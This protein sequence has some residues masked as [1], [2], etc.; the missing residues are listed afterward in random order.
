MKK[1]YTLFLIIFIL[2]FIAAP[3]AEA[4]NPDR[5]GEAGAPELLMNPWARSAGLHTM[6]TS[7]VTGVDAMRLNVAGLSRINRTEVALS[8]ARYLDG[9]GIFMNAFGLA[10]RIGQKNSAFGVTIMA[11]DFGDIPVTTVNQPEGTGSTF[12]PSWINIGLAYSHTFEEKISVGILLRG[13]FESTSDVDASGFGIDAGVQYVTGP[14]DN[15]KFG[16]SLRNVGSRMAFGGQGLNEFLSD[17]T[18][19]SEGRRVTFQTRAADFELPSVLN[20]GL[21]YDF[22]LQEKNRL[23]VLGNFTANS[24]ARDEVGGGVEF[25]FMD[26]FALRG[27]YK[28]EFGNTAEGENTIGESIYSGLSLGAS[29]QVPLKKDSNNKLGIDYGYRTTSPFKGTHNLGL[30]ISI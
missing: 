25:S 23:T 30:R 19:S 17:P 11:L 21:S 29:I 15:F 28:Y 26:K 1:I 18:N 3:V 13:V 22:I 2:A 8:H 6:N 9:T 12:S 20:I 27:G 24:F 7:F 5:Q 14:Q 4:G 10:Q 16:I